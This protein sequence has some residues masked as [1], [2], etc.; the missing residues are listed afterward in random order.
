MSNERRRPPPPP[1]SQRTNSIVG[2]FPGASVALAMPTQVI[3]QSPF[4]DD[5]ELSIPQSSAAVINNNSE[6]L[7]AGSEFYSGELD[8]YEIGSDESGFYNPQEFA[9]ED[10]SSELFYPVDPE[11]HGSND[12]DEVRL[13][14]LNLLI[15]IFILSSSLILLLLQLSLAQS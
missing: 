12:G 13:T 3:M 11:F 14:S 8:E 10:F 15:L 2:V 5:L 1:L 6:L 4:D 7:R 9:T